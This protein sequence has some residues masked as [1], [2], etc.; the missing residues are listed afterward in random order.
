MSNQNENP[1]NSENI[2]TIDQPKKRNKHNVT[3][4]QLKSFFESPPY[5]FDSSY[6]SASSFFQVPVQTLAS[7]LK[8]GGLSKKDINPFCK[9]DE[10]AI[11]SYVT[12]IGLVL[13]KYPHLTLKRL[14][15]LRYNYRRKHNLNSEL[16][17]A[18]QQTFKIK[19]D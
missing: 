17:P 1:Q 7:I 18:A 19:K 5:P 3:L 8:R 4:E 11:Y 14:H 12:S 10:I 15:T 13:D 2:E 9:N 16:L 6:K